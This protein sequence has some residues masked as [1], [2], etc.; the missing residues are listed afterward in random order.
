MSFVRREADLIDLSTF[1]RRQTNTQQTTQRAGGE[2]APDGLVAPPGLLTR[3]ATPGT[4]HWS[5]SKSAPDNTVIDNTLS[6]PP[7]RPTPRKTSFR[8]YG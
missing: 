1:R 2:R 4:P 7:D 5:P 8:L 6:Q 3:P